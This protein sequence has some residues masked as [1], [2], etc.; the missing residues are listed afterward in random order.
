MRRIGLAL[1]LGV[2]AAGTAQGALPRGLAFSAP[3]T[4]ITSPLG[5]GDASSQAT[6]RPTTGEPRVIVSRSG[7]VLVSAQFQQWNCE[8]RTPSS[9]TA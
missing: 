2:L 3:V 8:T 5:P 7:R 1:A 9:V 6:Q 4:V